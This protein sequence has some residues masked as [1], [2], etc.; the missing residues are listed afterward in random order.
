MVSAEGGVLAAVA[1]LKGSELVALIHYAEGL[2][3]SDG[4]NEVIAQALIVAAGRYL[5]RA[6]RKTKKKLKKAR[7]VF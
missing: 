2:E 4:R 6:R 3:R 5:E 7:R 1:A